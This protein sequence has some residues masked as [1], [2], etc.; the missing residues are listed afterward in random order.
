MVSLQERRDLVSRKAR[1]RSSI[2]VY[3]VMVRGLNKMPIFK[4]KRE[5]TRM[6]N[7]IRENLSKYKVDIYAYCVMSNHFH[8]LIRA[9][10]KEL[11]SFMAKILAA[12]AN[13][14]NY[15]H[16]R[17]GYVFQDRYKSQCVEDESYFWNCMRYIHS[18]PSTKGE[19]KEL[20]Q[21]QH[22]SMREFYTGKKDIVAEETFLMAEN[23]FRT[24]QDFLEFH[25][26]GSW[27]VFDDV[28]EDTLNNNTRIA[29][30][31]LDTYSWKYNL[32]EEE[33][34]QYVKTRREYEKELSKVLQISR[35]SIE[36][37]EKELLKN[38][39]RDRE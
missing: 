27:E 24:K 11:A 9:D 20:L 12:F 34:L 29:Q 16:H 6:V 37:L 25:K 36:L 5:K 14:Y 23:R 2:D 10:L 19:I 22:S 31:I 8:L 21:Y 33:I 28:Y 15:K 4:E 7:L 30:E 38:L 1:K 26:S 35:K 18:N 39:K 32:S 17:V 13:Y 3:H